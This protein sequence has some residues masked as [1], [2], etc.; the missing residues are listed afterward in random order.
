MKMLK[1]ATDRDVGFF[2]SQAMVLMIKAD[3]SGQ[4]LRRDSLNFW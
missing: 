4:C 2:K 3:V 1:R